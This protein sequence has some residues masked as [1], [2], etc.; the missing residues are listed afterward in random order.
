[1]F[2]QLLKIELFKTFKRPRTYIAFGTVAVI[3][4]LVQFAL[5]ANGEDLIKIF[6][7]SQES[8]F[9]IPYTKILN[10]YFVCVTILH[11]ILIHLPLLVALISGD[12]IS[13][14]ANIGTLR[15]LAAKP[16]SRFEIIMAKF[17]ASVVYLMLLLIFMALLS[18]F[19]SLL[20]FGSGD[21]LVFKENSIHQMEA[22]DVLW[23]FFAAFGFAT[24]A[25][26]TV[27]ALALMLSVFAENSIGPIVG[28]VCII[29]VFTIVQQLQVPVF[30]DTVTPWLFTTHMLGWKGFFYVVATEEGETIRG[31]IE[32]SG[33]IFESAMILVAY[34]VLFLTVAVWRFNKKDILS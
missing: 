20:V 13:G 17:A 8:D 26:T 31:S 23:R 1:M 27:S 15:L 9:D 34:I 30:K 33:A 29:I 6:I 4:V 2:L 11:T 32:N 16:I 18:L 3:V 24:L 7:S 28:T 10:G 14:E 21:L 19:I 22:G 5:K 25:L 12:A